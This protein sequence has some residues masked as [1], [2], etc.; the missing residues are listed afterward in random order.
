M[1]IKR[2]MLINRHCQYWNIINILWYTTTIDKNRTLIKWVMLIE[3]NLIFS[4]KQLIC[5][6]LMP[7]SQKTQT[8]KFEWF[9]VNDQRDAQIPFYVFIFIFN[10]LHVSSTSCASSGETNCVNTT[11]G[12]CHSLLVAVSC[13]GWEFTPNLHTTPNIE[14]NLC[15]TLV[16]YQ[17]SL[18]DARSSKI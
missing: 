11:S 2:V 7:T 8:I 3:K 4:I 1:P 18:R 12:N 14:M 16:I 17:E 10:S 5:K 13:V 6:S 9:L 15:V